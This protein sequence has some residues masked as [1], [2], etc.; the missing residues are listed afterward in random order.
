MSC[1]WGSTV[2]PSKLD[3]LQTRRIMQQCLSRPARNGERTR[4]RL[5]VLSPALALRPAGSLGRSHPRSPGEHEIGQIHRRC[6]TQGQRV[7]AGLPRR[8]GALGRSAPFGDSAF[9]LAA[10]M[11]SRA[12]MTSSEPWKDTFF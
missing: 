9:A 7:G 10:S 2:R 3:S 12:P 4:V 5:R 8:N 6:D 11:S 1:L